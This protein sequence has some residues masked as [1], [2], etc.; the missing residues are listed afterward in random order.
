MAQKFR[1]TEERPS[2]LQINR[3]VPP[4]TPPGQRYAHAKDVRELP[5]GETEQERVYRL[6]WH[7]SLRRSVTPLA[8]SFLTGDVTGGASSP[9][10][11]PAVAA[12][13]RP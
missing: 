9:P 1:V 8:P 7:G 10:T 5:G 3:V 11:P 6:L 2:S 4:G 13:S 12:Q